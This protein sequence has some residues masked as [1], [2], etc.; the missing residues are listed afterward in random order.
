MFVMQVDD[1]N[2]F[3]EAKFRL[4]TQIK[5]NENENES[6]DS[7]VILA[8]MQ[9]ERSE[10]VCFESRF[11]EVHVYALFLERDLH[12]QFSGVKRLS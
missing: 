7:Y 2:M 9:D 3:V 1:C 12:F 11:L 4:H 5:W 8:K 10:T 6:R